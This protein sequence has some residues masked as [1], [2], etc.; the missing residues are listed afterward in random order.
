MEA[1][2]KRKFLTDMRVSRTDGISVYI[3]RPQADGRFEFVAYSKSSYLF[4]LGYAPATEGKSW[5]FWT[6]EIYMDQDTK[7]KKKRVTVFRNLVQQLERNE[8]RE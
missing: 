6:D 7:V 5:G 1:T 8:K 3:V 4:N 2:A